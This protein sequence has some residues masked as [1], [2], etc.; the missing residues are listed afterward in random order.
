MSH[1]LP[2]S[3]CLFSSTKGH[4]GRKTDWRITLDHWNKQ[5]PLSLFNLV[6][7]LKVSPD[8]E[9]LGNEMESDLRGRGF[10]VIKTVGDWKRGLSHGES[11]LGDQIIVSKD[12]AI[13]KCPYFLLV[14]DDSPVVCNQGTL[15]DLLLKSCDMLAANHELVTV[16]TIRRGD[17]EG[18]VPQITPDEDPRYFWSPNTDFQ[19]MILRSLDFYRL[20]VILEANPEYCRQVQCEALWAA[21]LRG[22]SRS[23]KR[24]LVW[25][26]SFAETIHIGVAEPEHSAALNKLSL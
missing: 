10:H 16:R 12:P 11:Y 15:E 23:E 8:E 22:F 21:I 26:P 24:H 6:A 4:H 3:L 1:R 13:Y 14:E 9:G 2:I 17:Y 25:K 18:G 20:G 7:H 19:P 5:V